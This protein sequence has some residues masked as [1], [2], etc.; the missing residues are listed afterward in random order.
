[1]AP[2]EPAAPRIADDERADETTPDRDDHDGAYHERER[3]DPGRDRKPSGV[4]VDDDIVAACRVTVVGSAL[5][6]QSLPLVRP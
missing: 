1:M 3:A 5:P 2:L 6:R 4:D